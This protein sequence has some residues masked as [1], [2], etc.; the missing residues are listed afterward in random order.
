[1]R[2]GKLDRVVQLQHQVLGSRS[3]TGERATTYTTYATVRAG[4][5]D[6]RGRELYAANQVQAEVSTVFEIRYRDDVLRTDRIV[7]EGVNYNVRHV[8]EI[9]RGR[10][11]E[12][13]TTALVS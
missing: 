13:H 12:V 9:G 7:C 4:K 8:A 6:L 2:A 1:M 5:K 10:G 3:S 11:L